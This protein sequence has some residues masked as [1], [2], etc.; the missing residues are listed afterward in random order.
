MRT[1]YPNRKNLGFT[2]IEMLVYISILTLVSGGALT[3]LFSLGDQINAARAERLLSHSAQTALERMLYDIKE[4]DYADIFL[5]DFDVTPGVLR[6]VQVASTTE[7]SVAANTLYYAKDDVNQGPLTDDRVSVDSL[8]FYHYDNS[9]TELVRIAMTLTVTVGETT[10][11]RTFNAAT[12][13]R[14]SYD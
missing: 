13:L 6:V 11:T 7:F 14:G 2:L 3:L 1:F 5:S 12:T 4:A 9:V 10:I 8:Y